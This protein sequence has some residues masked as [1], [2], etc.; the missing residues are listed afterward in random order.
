[1]VVK[2]ERGVE[3]MIAY[4]FAHRIPPREKTSFTGHCTVVL[5]CGITLFFIHPCLHFTTHHIMS[6]HV[7]TD[8]YLITAYIHSSAQNGMF[9]HVLNVQ[10]PKNHSR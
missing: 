1:M 3:M 2:G 10:S 6:R 4:I 9:T 7:R 5:Y 8:S